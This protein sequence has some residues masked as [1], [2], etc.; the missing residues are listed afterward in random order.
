MGIQ[1]LRER[2]KGIA[3]NLR[4]MTDNATGPFNASQQA[5]WEAGISE[6]DALEAQIG[7]YEQMLNRESETSQANKAKDRADYEG[8]SL[9]EAHHRNDVGRRMF[10]AWIR[11]GSEALTSDQR[12]ALL[13]DQ[14]AANKIFGALAVGTDSAGGF[15]VSKEWSTQVIGRM[16]AFG[17]PRSV[18]TILSTDGG[19]T[20]NYP[21]SDGTTETGELIAE[22][23]TATEADATFSTVA[24]GAYKFSSKFIAVPFELLQDSA[25]D[26]EK[27]VGDR[28][29]TRLGRSQGAFFTTGTGTGQPQGVV[30]AAGTVTAAL[31]GAISY[32]DLVELQHAVDPA[33]RAAGKTAFML[34]DSVLKVIRK[35]LDSQGR[36]IWT[37]NIEAGASSMLLGEKVVINQHM[38]AVTT[39]GAKSVLFGDFE[40][41][42]V[43]DAMQAQLFRMTDSAFLKLGQVGFLA[44]MRADGRAIAHTATDVFKVLT[45][46]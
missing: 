24:L 42:V 40:Q 18:A 29:A 4:R 6:M 46:P 10:N 33:Y 37:P 13:R 8:I 23:V 20:I 21:C 19:N 44:W 5:A 30:T 11:G 31:A 14:N 32:G 45:H 7:R 34:H 3:I 2:R 12:D 22:N 36:P 26:I 1:E 43:R 27:F 41:Y 39:T 35:L 15:T 25:I 16:K 38:S 28:L 17:G 9:D